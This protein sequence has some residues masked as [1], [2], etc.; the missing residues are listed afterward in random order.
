[1]V[2]V[3]ILVE[4]APHEFSANYLFDDR[5]LFPYPARLTAE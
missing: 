3:T 1:V 4:T 5:G 2:V